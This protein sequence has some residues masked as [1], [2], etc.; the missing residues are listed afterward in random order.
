[1]QFLS[2]GQTIETR[3]V[4]KQNSVVEFFQWWSPRIPGVSLTDSELIEVLHE[5]ED[6]GKVERTET[7]TGDTCEYV[8]TWR[9]C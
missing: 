2:N 9:A 4:E 7:P 3:L 1:L 6:A 8:L 5:L